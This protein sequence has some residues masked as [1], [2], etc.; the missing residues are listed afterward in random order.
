MKCGHN[1]LNVSGIFTRLSLRKKRSGFLIVKLNC[2][3]F[4]LRERYIHHLNIMRIIPNFS[5]DPYLVVIYLSLTLHYLPLSFT[6]TKK[7]LPNTIKIP[8]TTNT[9]M[10]EDILIRLI[11][12]DVDLTQRKSTHLLMSSECIDRLHIKRRAPKSERKE[13]VFI[14]LKVSSKQYDWMYAIKTPLEISTLW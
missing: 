14:I 9:Y 11:Y 2:V 1:F 10:K 8:H 12:N 3:N 4:I 6:F 5:K 13:D 7:M